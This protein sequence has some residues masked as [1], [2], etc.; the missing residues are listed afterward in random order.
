L[1]YR[2]GKEAGVEVLLVTSRQTGRWI[3]PKGWPIKGF[4]PAETAAQ[5]AYEEA[6]VRGD[7]SGRSLGRYVYEK[8]TEDRVASFPCEVQVFPLLVKTQLKKWPESGQRRV[9]WLR[10]PEAA[11]VIED[12]DLR[13]LILALEGRGLAVPRKS[14]GARQK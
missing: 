7:V 11:A 14:K 13:K 3:I 1:P 4:K 5:E 12:G 2:F 10:V 9:R 6:G 8:R